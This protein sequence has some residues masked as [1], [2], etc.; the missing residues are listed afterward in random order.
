MMA[1]AYKESTWDPAAKNPDSSATGLYQILNGT[2]DDI[3]NRVHPNF[4]SKREMCGLEGGK[5]LR[6]CRKE[7]GIATYAAVIYLFDRIAARRNNLRDGIAAY[8]TGAQYARKVIAG[9]D[10][11]K[12]I[13]GFESYSPTLGKAADC[14]CHKCEEIKKGLERTVR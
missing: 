12:R 5:R 10:E 2:A 3:Q 11:I 4:V 9:A 6:D 14:F 13:C 8:G 1:I 7:P